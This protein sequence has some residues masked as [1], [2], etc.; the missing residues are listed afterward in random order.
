MKPSVI[1]TSHDVDKAAKKP[2]TTLCHG[3]LYFFTAVTRGCDVL[4]LADLHIVQASSKGRRPIRASQ[5]YKL[6]TGHVTRPLTT[7]SFSSQPSLALK[8]KDC[9][10]NFH[11]DNTEHS[12]AKIT[13]VV[14]A[15]S[16]AM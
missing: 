9:S 13:P 4:I 10:Y 5:H 7:I 2:F 6:A 3:G 1:D 8:I 15:T 14:P 16:S 12:L 11:Q